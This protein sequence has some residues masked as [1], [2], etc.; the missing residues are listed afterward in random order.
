MADEAIVSCAEVQAITRTGDRV[1]GGGVRAPFHNEALSRRAAADGPSALVSQSRP[2]LPI[3]A[4]PASLPGT[5]HRTPTTRPIMKGALSAE[6]GFGERPARPGKTLL[7]PA[8]QR[9]EGDAV[10]RR[11]DEPAP[12][13]V[14]A[15]VVDLRRF[16]PRAGSSP[17]QDVGRLQLRERD[18]LCRR[19]LAAHREG[20][21]A[22]ERARERRAAGVG[23]KLV[24]APHESGA[25]EAPGSL[26]ADRRL[27]LLSCAAPDVG[28]S[29]EV[30]CR[31]ANR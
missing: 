14:D 28:L 27:G 1:E 7:V 26:D 16:R 22:L 3:R 8:R 23:L 29:D 21:S 13:E 24:D 30:R 10:A 9:S 5:D 18:A 6:L 25:V 19:H 11:V 15:R 4:L 2:V 17:E 31:L 20:G 12:A